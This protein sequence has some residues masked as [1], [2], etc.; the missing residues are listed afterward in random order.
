M[1]TDI[2]RKAVIPTSVGVA[3]L[4]V[5]GVLGFILGQRRERRRRLSLIEQAEDAMRE[6]EE[7]VR[8]FDGFTTTRNLPTG[9][10]RDPAYIGKPHDIT[11]PNARIPYYTVPK[12]DE[13]IQDGLRTI[14]EIQLQSL[15]LDLEPNVFGG[16]VE[17]VEPSK[18][19]NI[20]V[21]GRVYDA[22]DDDWNW[23]AELNARSNL[24]I[25][26]ITL[27]EFRADDMGFR[28]S[29]VTFYEGDRMVCDA[30]GEAIYN[31]TSHIGTELPFGHGTEGDENVV[32]IRNESLK[33][34]YEVCR[35]PG[36]F[37]V[38]VQGHQIEL[39]YEEEDLK[40]AH[41]PLKMRRE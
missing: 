20:F 12:T 26:V 3:G 11:Q 14:T 10:L 15:S 22:S 1:N 36:R 21:D 6:Y 41:Q 23:E 35:D 24:D 38:E 9:D 7:G 31:W 32:F 25:Y 2:L 5:G 28:Q 18:P 39:A 34:E 29:T 19:K 33:W 37:D 13:E 30:L 8:P 17:L 16:T 4:S 40:H 27:D